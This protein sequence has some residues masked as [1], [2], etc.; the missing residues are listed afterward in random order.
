MI[1]NGRHYYSCFNQLQ[2]IYSY[3]LYIYS[4]SHCY[5]LILLLNLYP[6]YITSIQSLLLSCN[7]YTLPILLHA[8]PSLHIKAFNYKGLSNQLLTWQCSQ[9]HRKRP[10]QLLVQLELPAK[11]NLRK[12]FLKV[13]NL[14]DKTGCCHFET[15]G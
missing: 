12:L 6:N 10:Y 15:E 11:I 2:N 4:S 1:Y 7:L 9:T 13:V 3:F 5:I 8:I 14:T